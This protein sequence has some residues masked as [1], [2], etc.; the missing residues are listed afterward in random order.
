ML[1]DFIAKTTHARVESALI[2][3][4]FLLFFGVV[5]GKW[6]HVKSAMHHS[7]APDSSACESNVG[8]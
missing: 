2:V 3:S 8:G 5:L 4:R 1:A 7:R 6:D